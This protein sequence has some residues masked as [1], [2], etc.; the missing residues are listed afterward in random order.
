MRDEI[1]ELQEFARSD[2]P[3]IKTIVMTVLQA[4]GCA[5]VRTLFERNPDLAFE[6]H[7]EI[8][9]LID[10]TAEVGEFEHDL[11]RETM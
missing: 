11:E 6:L 8:R 5:T 9:G 4:E 10:D 2:D 3:I 7:D 1:E